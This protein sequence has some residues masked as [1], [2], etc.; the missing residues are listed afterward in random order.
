MSTKQDLYQ[1]VT[2]RIVAALEA[3][4]SPTAWKA[5]WHNIG[6]PENAVTHKAYRGVNTVVLW[7][8]QGLRGFTTHY[9]AT[10]KQWSEKGC[11]VRRGETATT[12]LLFKPGARDV[13]NE[14]GDSQR[15]R[16]LITRAYKVFNA[17]QVDGWTPPVEKR[18]VF[19][20]NAHA[21]EFFA[22]IGASID[23]GG[24]RACYYPS[25]DRIALPLPEQF[26]DT[27]SYYA[28]SAHEHTHWTAHEKRC[29]REG[30]L[31]NKFGDNKYAAE[32]LVAELGSAYVCALLGLV[33][34][35]RADHAEYVA[36]WITV[37]K[38]DPSAI[39]TAASKA[40]EA[41]DWLVAHAE[42]AEHG[43]VLPTEGTE[44]EA[45]I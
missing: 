10:Y 22:A 25:I 7:A 42:D 1:Q 6:L 15:Q 18:S 26:K 29:N 40:Q 37:L 41:V 43:P 23:H 2:D 44:L 38:N 11:Q 8:E 24:N 35:P 14:T 39:V 34:E 12:V 30:A 27:A 21:E 9:W 5:P 31:A 28:T 45:A 4:V 19:E 33:N 17:D 36:N 16:F 3:G 20:I 13:E 32:E